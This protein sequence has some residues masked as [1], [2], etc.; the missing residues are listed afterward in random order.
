MILQR[1]IVII[2]GLFTLS[3]IADDRGI[4][5]TPEQEMSY[6]LGMAV[7]GRLQGQSVQVDADFY[8]QGFRDALEGRSTRISEEE[9]RTSVAALQRQARLG[10]TLPTSA[11]QVVEARGGWLAEGAGVTVPEG[12]EIS[13]RL[14]PRITR[15][16][17]MGERWVSPPTFTYA[18]PPPDESLTVIA[19]ARGV[20]GPGKHIDIE[21]QWISG[22]GELLRV[23]PERG[24]EVTL[25]AVGE[26]SS[27]LTVRYGKLARELTVRVVRDADVVRMEVIQ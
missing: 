21:P 1:L 18:N 13:F 6:A 10:R 22:D 19:R 14:D 3:S 2:I 4:A 17:Y 5:M 11:P 27:N 9:M 15:G 20:L 26:G 25:V 16:L 7:A 8:V 23:V 24:R 12:I